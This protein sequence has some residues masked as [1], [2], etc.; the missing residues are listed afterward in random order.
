MPAAPTSA[1]SALP[2]TDLAAHF[3]ATRLWLPAEF[4]L[5]VPV[6]EGPASLTLEAMDADG[7]WHAL[8]TLPLTIAADGQPT[9]RVEG[10]V[11]IR[12]EGSW[13]VRD[14]HHPFHG[15]LDEPGVT[16]A[17]RDG[18]ARVF[19]WLL[20]ETCPL[21]GVLATTDTLVFNHLAHSRTDDALAAKVGHPGAGRAR[22]RGAVDFPVTL[23]TPACLRVYAVSPDGSV[24]LCFGAAP[25]LPQGRRLR[26]PRARSRTH[27]RSYTPHPNIA[28]CPRY[29]RAG[30]AA[31]SS[32]CAAC[33]RT[34]RR[35]ARS[36]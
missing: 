25:V 21:A 35:C 17:L 30:R 16:P 13:T 18:R 36:I 14:A 11:E 8:Q 3:R 31:C 19:G 27:I 22:L 4:I 10:R 23:A 33:F 28:P 5:G 7:A 29:P 9:P 15:H 12:P 24:T 1:C 2:R 6:T 34:T 20:D 26:R 32:S